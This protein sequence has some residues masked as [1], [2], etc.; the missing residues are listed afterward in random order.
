MCCLFS[1]FCVWK[2]VRAVLKV[3]DFKRTVLNYSFSRENMA[4]QRVMTAEDSDPILFHRI[5]IRYFFTGAGFDTFSPDPD[6]ILFHRS[7][8]RYFFTGAGF[9]TF[10][11]DPDP[12]CYNRYILYIYKYKYVFV[13]WI[14]FCNLN[15]F[16]YI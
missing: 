12:T 7:R 15:L 14:C 16:L 3:W 10:S 1:I 4:R 5:R 6:P 11:P 13:I 9:D 2:A 8:I